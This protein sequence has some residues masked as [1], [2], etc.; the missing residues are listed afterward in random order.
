MEVPA[1]LVDPSFRARAEDNPR[2]ALDSDGTFSVCNLLIGKMH[3]L[4]SSIS[5]L[6]IAWH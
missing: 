4:L 3:Y 6:A 5:C 1:G 2:K